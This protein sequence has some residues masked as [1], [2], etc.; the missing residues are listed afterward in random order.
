MKIK[1]FFNPKEVYDGYLD[2]YFIRP[3]FHHFADFKGRESATSCILSI[4]VWLIATLGI[5]GIILGQIAFLGPELGFKILTCFCI[6][7]A[8]ISIIPIVALV[9]RAT[10]GQPAK[11]LRTRMLGVDS[12]LI[13]CCLLFFVIGLLMMSTTVNSGLLHPDAGVYEEPDKSKIN[14]DQVSEEPIFTYQEENTG[15]LD[16]S[17]DSL[18]DMNETDIIDIEDSFDPT[19]ES[20]TIDHSQ[21]ADSSYYF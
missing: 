7:W 9:V 14:N 16:E 6:T 20:P 21:P 17:P 11:P 18:S 10:N 5:I 3:F 12:F 8:V 13:I 4:L 19:I 2:S 15:P 1:E